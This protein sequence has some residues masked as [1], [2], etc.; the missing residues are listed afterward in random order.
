MQYLPG[1]DWLRVH[2]QMIHFFGLGFVQLKISNQQRYHFYHP[3]LSG[4]SEEPHDHRHA[5]FSTVL[6]GALK[7][8]IWE[9]HPN[10]DEMELQYASCR[11][12]D[13]EIPPPYKTRARRSGS[14]TVRAGSSYY[15]DADTF[16]Q[17]ALVGESPCISFLTKRE[18]VKDLARVLVTVGETRA[19]PFSR[20]LP[21]PKLWEI[22]YDCLT[23]A[24]T[25]AQE[26]E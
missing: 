12:G 13:V 23:R 16:H 4:F 7:H 10:G 14:F 19:C 21:E 24:Q 9:E 20:D 15:L 3:Y 8:H 6:A 1:I 5:F 2:C 17:V 26:R 11:T 18:N 25:T 22:V